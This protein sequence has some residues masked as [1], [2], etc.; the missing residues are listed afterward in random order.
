MLPMQS[1]RVIEARFILD[2]PGKVKLRLSD[3]RKLELPQA[4]AASGVRYANAK[5]TFIF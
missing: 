5:E 2:E 4:A 3:G 1:G